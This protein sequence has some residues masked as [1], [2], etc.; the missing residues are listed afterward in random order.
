[1]KILLMLCDA[2][3]AVDGK[4][5]VLGGGWSITPTPDQDRSRSR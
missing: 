1:M 5:Y 3:Q 4:L 2:A